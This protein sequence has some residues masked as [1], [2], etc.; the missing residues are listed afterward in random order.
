MN[1]EAMNLK[2]DMKSGSATR[3]LLCKDHQDRP[4]ERGVVAPPRLNFLK[5]RE[6]QRHLD[7]TNRLL[8]LL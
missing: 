4:D 1:P 2:V 7:R 5:R 6:N 3:P 8:K